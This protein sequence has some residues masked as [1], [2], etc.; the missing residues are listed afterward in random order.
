[1]VEVEIE[2]ILRLFD[3]DEEFMTAHSISQEVKSNMTRSTS[4][5]NVIGQIQGRISLII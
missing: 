5:S 2:D 1:M 3:K 4:I